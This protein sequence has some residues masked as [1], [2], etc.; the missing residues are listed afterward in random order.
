MKFTTSD[1]IP[2][3]IIIEPD[4]YGDD[5]G[6]FFES[7]QREKYIQH[8]ISMAL[9]Q[10]NISFSKR[11]VLRGLHY[12]L[13]N[14]QGKLVLAVSGEIFDVAVDIRKGS[15]TFSKWTGV[16]LS[17]DNHLQV[18]IPKGFAHGYCVLSEKAYIIYKCT[19]YYA[20]FEE[21]GILWN[22]TSLNITWPVDEPVI[23]ERDRNL[24]SLKN[25]DEN[26]FP[27]F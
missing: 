8:D 24:P 5:R 9:V 22:D 27:V 2:E 25:I 3:V 26:D 7:Y 11:G 16:T 1:I 18:Y 13:G 14:P 10:D 21:R 20:P 15:P 19:D 12:Q 17:S 4:V 23:S 6:F